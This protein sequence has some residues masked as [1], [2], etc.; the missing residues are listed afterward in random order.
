MHA[1]SR[2]AL[3]FVWDSSHRK[4]V[5]ARGSDGHLASP[6]GWDSGTLADQPQRGQEDSDLT[7]KSLLSAPL[8]S[9]GYV[10]N[11]LQGCSEERRPQ[12]TGEIDMKRQH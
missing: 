10:G 8:G 7:V 12:R 11:S 9:F 6:R 1:G 3:L 5:S 2:I 4:E